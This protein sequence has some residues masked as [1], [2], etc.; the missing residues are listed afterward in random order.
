MLL[1]DFTTGALAIAADPTFVL[2]V[3]AAAI[4]GL[5]GRVA[6]GIRKVTR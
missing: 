1:T 2:A 4:G 3:G 5:F 6:W